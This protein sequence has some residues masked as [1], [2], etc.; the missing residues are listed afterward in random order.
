M[1][2][3]GKKRRSLFTVNLLETYEI[4]LKLYRRRQRQKKIF[5]FFRSFGYTA[6]LFVMISISM[7]FVAMKIDE[8]S[9]STENTDGRFGYFFQKL[10]LEF[11]DWK[12]GRMDEYEGDFFR[13][14]D[15]VNSS[16][17]YAVN[18]KVI[19][20]VDVGK[21]GIF[22]DLTINYALN[23]NYK[24]DALQDDIQ[25]VL[26]LGS[27]ITDSNSEDF[28]GKVFTQNKKTI[29]Q[30]SITLENDK[31]TVLHI[32]YKLPSYIEDL[33]RKGIY[34]VN[35]D[36][37]GFQ[38][39]DTLLFDLYFDQD[40]K[41]YSPKGIYINKINNRNINWETYADTDKE[42]KVIF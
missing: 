16:L 13:I 35:V 7:F 19:Y 4:L 24:S 23:S 26:P 3:L 37:E 21:Y 1:V 38:S 5:K 8:L 30:T 9:E 6:L 39:S 29:Y 33:A 22:A 10:K 14:N 32:R 15:F 31:I 28:N 12:V 2:M 17:S 20:K 27:V 25:L 41:T 34:Q 42:I 18:K 11:L 36:R 40:I